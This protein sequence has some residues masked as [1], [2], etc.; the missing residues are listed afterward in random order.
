MG[1]V[2]IGVVHGGRRSDDVAL[3]TA[4]SHKSDVKGDHCDEGGPGPVCLQK[5]RRS[6]SLP[7]CADSLY[8]VRGD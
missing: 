7:I 5:S 1:D 4:A 6:D 2:Q 8:G 3:E